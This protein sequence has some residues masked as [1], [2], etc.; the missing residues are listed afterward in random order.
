MLST[1]PRSVAEG[2]GNLSGYGTEKYVSLED[3]L[4]YFFIFNYKEH[5]C[6]FQWIAYILADV[7]T[8]ECLSLAF[9]TIAQAE[10]LP[11]LLKWTLLKGRHGTLLLLLIFISLTHF[12]VKRA[13][14]ADCTILLWV[15]DQDCFS[16]L[17]CLCLALL[18]LRMPKGR[19]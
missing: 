15:E 9:L 5:I 18:I 4:N 13:F 3:F 17:G 16:V 14:H 1:T 19:S 11:I 7:V 10:F 8:E 6:S 2:I 12:V